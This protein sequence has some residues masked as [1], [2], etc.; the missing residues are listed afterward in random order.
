MSFASIVEERST[1]KPAGI[2]E[3]Q[4]LHLNLIQHYELNKRISHLLDALFQ[5]L[6]DTRTQVNGIQYWF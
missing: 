5:T 3:R 4:C 2:E 1:D 6:V